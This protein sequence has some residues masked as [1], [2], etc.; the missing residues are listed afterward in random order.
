MTVFFEQTGDFSNRIF[1]VD[2][3]SEL[4]CFNLI[5][6]NS[7]NGRRPLPAVVSWGSKIRAGNFGTLRMLPAYRIRNCCGVQSGDLRQ[8]RLSI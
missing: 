6:L 2:G 4:N 8:F 7:I 1:D 3:Q 5:Q